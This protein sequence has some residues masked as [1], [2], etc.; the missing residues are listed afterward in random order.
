MADIHDK[1]IDSRNFVERI[2]AM[3]PGFKGYMNKELRR[4]TD[5]IQREFCAK[6]LTD[7]KAAVKSALNDVISGGDIDGIAPFEKLT[8]RID[9][10]A[11]KILYAN[12]GYSGMFDTIKVGEDVL[13]RVYQFD[14][15]L[16]E[17]VGEVAKKIQQFKTVDK[18]TMLNL[19]KE[20]IALLDSVEEYFGKREE[21]LKKGS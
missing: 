21:I 20:A 18:D 9:V 16:A 6:T 5:K 12:R 11:N 7:S 10:V 1:A 14:L 8:N 4:D 15:S 19:V 17:G 3:I 2:G 13:E